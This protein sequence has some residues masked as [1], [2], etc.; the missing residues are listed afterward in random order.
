MTIKIGMEVIESIVTESVEVVEHATVSNLD[1]EKSKAGE[2][3]PT[4]VVSR[5]HPP[6][7]ARRAR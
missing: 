7:D 2:C 5:L 6:L 3:F 1:S 4:Y